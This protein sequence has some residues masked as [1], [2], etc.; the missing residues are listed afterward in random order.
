MDQLI[1]CMESH[2]MDQWGVCRFEDALPLL[3][4]RAKR[5][6]PE[7]AK[8]IIVILFGYYIGEYPNRNISRYALMDDYHTVIRAT[9]EE[10]A[11]ELQNMYN[12]DVFI[13][14]V[15]S[16]PVAEV[17][18]ASLAGLGDIGMNG[19]LLNETYGSYCFIGEIVTT[20]DF[21]AAGRKANPLCTHC[22]RCAAACPTGALSQE[23]FNR[24]KCRSH[25]TQKKGELTEWEREQIRAGGFVWG[26]DRCTDACPVNRNARRS[27]V[28]A[29][30]RDIAPVVGEDNLGKLCESKAY[31]WRGETV[32]RRNLR[33][34]RGEE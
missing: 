19:Q 28:A 25:I 22:G 15:D 3:E 2:G 6:L 31:G 8:S 20:A 10:L 21:P 33:I 5:R 23:G 27:P 14:F 26:C 29:F 30:Q 34:L 18:A 12:G 11:K 7:R 4:V 13:P 16:S 1:K 32:L 9:L 24:E 17:R